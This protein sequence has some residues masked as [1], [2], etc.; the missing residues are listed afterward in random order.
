MK[1]DTLDAGDPIDLGRRYSALR[2]DFPAC[3]SSA[4]LRGTDHRHLA[5]ICEACVPYEAKGRLRP[6][7]ATRPDRITGEAAIGGPPLDKLPAGGASVAGEDFDMTTQSPGRFRAAGGAD[8]PV[9]PAFCALASRV[10]SSAPTW[11]VFNDHLLRDIGLTRL[12]NRLLPPR[13]TRPA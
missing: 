3:A 2:R 9:R 6:A 5:A 7:R 8:R 13:L 1:S 10:G 4:W 12:P 11:S